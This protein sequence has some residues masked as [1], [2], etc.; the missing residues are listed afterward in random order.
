[1]TTWTRTGSCP[2]ATGTSATSTRRPDSPNRLFPLLH[3]NNRALADL[4]RDFKLVHQSLY[5]GQANSEATGGGVS[6][7]DGAVNVGDPLTLVTGNDHEAG[8]PPSIE[9][10]QDNL[11]ALGI[12]QNIAGEFRNR[13]GHQ[14]PIARTK[15]EPL[16]HRA[17]A[18]TRR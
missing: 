1:M 5:A 11:A 12:K 17:A 16:R 15:A 14:R 2:P 18:V 8:P 7:A 4:R 10:P 13:S 6:I 3:R 9:G